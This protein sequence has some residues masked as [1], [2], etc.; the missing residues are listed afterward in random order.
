MTKKVKPGHK[1]QLSQVLGNRRLTAS[2]EWL[3]GA[4]R[5]WGRARKE[6]GWIPVPESGR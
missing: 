2:R 4:P 6:N 5:A 1:R 3:R